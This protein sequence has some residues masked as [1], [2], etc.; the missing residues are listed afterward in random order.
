MSLPIEITHEVTLPKVLKEF[1]KQ[2][3]ADDMVADIIEFICD[4]PDTQ[5]EDKLLARLQK[6]KADNE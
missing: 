3:S 1:R 4:Q 6:F 5:F 2:W